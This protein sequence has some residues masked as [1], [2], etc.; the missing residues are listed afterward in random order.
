MTI[1]DDIAAAQAEHNADSTALDTA[2]T[3]AQRVLDE[4]APGLNEDFGFIDQNLVALEA[5]MQEEND[6]IER[7]E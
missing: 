4:Q 3:R 2:L 5:D 1:S 7:G 6:A